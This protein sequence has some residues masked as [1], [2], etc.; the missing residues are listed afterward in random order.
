[1]SILLHLSNILKGQGGMQYCILSYSVPGSKIP[2][3]SHSVYIEQNF[4]GGNFDIFEFLILQS[5]L[6]HQF[7]V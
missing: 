6:S 4:N 1:M 5:K 7:F 3:K 2:Q